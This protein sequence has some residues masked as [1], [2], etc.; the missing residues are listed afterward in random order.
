MNKT[1]NRK[2]VIGLDL[3]LLLVFEA[4]INEHSVTKAAMHLGVS[5]SAVSASLKRLRVTYRDNLFIRGQRGIKPTPQA[6]LLQP[7]IE[8]ALALIRSTIEQNETQTSKTQ[9]VTI[10]VSDDF[11][12]AYGSQIIRALI[13]ALPSVRVV[14]RQTNSLL[15]GDALH[16]RNIDFALTSHI[17]KDTRIHSQFLGNSGYSCLY[18]PN[19]RRGISPITLDEYTTQ[20]HILV[21]YSG[22]TG[23]TDSVLLEQGLRR[24]VRSSTSHFSALPFL[25][26]GTDAIATIPSHA[27]DAIANCTSLQVST[28]PLAFPRYGINISWRFDT[29]RRKDMKMIRDCI[30]EVF[31]KREETQN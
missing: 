19:H 22:L 14:F 18:D 25:L 24:N 1:D 2:D 10:G 28:A 3:N 15:C 26:L 12:I 6:I 23:V 8:D 20:D 13:I 16:E 31:D 17:E 21:S 5:Q 29:M 4:L 30:V 11:E 9:L 7:I 27:A